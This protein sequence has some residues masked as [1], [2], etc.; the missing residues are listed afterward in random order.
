MAG[1]W[2][3]DWYCNDGGDSPTACNNVIA[4]TRELGSITTLDLSGAITPPMQCS[5]IYS[6]TRGR[7]KSVWTDHSC[8][9]RGG[10]HQQL[11][12]SHLVRGWSVYI[13][14]D[15]YNT[16]QM[17]V[18]TAETYNTLYYV[19][20]YSQ[21]IDL[22]ISA[23]S[24]GITSASALV[25]VGWYMA[26]MI[27]Q[28]SSSGQGAGLAILILEN[29]SPTWGFAK[30]CFFT[31][32]SRHESTDLA[33]CQEQ[34]SLRPVFCSS[35][36]KVEDWE[37]RG[38]VYD[39]E[40]EAWAERGPGRDDRQCVYCLI[41]VLVQLCRVNILSRSAHSEQLILPNENFVGAI[42]T[43]LWVAVLEGGKSTGVHCVERALM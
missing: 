40:F 28:E 7:I 6:E 26:I 39:R 31:G 8:D 42:P 12:K 10:S 1:Q 32:N 29:A 30:L 16:V 38:L 33:C 17:S 22:Y 20:V 18:R 43:L 27:I 2:S 21:R 4:T 13:R 23:V 35:K 15:T 14:A 9:I 11:Y 41:L 5:T 34:E 25:P 24:A 36:A 37:A 3:D 19:S